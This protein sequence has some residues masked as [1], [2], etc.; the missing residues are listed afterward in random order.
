MIKSFKTFESLSKIQEYT[1]EAF[2]GKRWKLNPDN[3]EIDIR[4]DVT[5]DPN[6]SLPQ[7]SKDLKIGKITGTFRFNDLSTYILPEY[8][9]RIVEGD[10]LAQNLKLETLENSPEYV[11]WDF[12]V[13]YNYLKDLK[14]SPPEIG[15]NF[16]VEG[17]TGLKSL[18]GGP[19][20]VKFT[21]NTAG[22]M[23]A[24]LEGFPEEIGGDFI[25]FLDGKNIRIKNKD[26]VL[27]KWLELFFEASFKGKERI[28]PIL[29][30]EKIRKE[31]ETNPEKT[32]FILSKY[33]KNPL[34]DHYFPYVKA[35]IPQKYRSE[36]ETL[37]DLD[38]LGF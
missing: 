16:S 6:L 15:G 26:I 5:I 33:S 1:L 22:C 31:I 25:M 9:P 30:E 12:V 37:S 32:T 10:F 14:G 21:Y 2:F 34:M 11:G 8:T 29:S 18:E 35:L 17:N 3:G 7:I 38:Q 20:K 24:T 13:E 27:S 28:K 19:K 4:G 36:Y 23:D